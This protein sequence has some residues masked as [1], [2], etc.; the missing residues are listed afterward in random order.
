MQ[1]IVKHLVFIN[2]DVP[3]LG[4]LSP[5]LDRRG[6]PIE[7]VLAALERQTHRRFIKTHLALDGLPYFPQVKYIVVARDAR[8][9]FMSL[10]NHYSN[11]TAEQYANLNETPGQVGPPLPHAPDDLHEFWQE[12]MTRG[13]FPW[14]SEGYPFWGN[15]H[16]TQTW[17]AFRHLENL[18]FVHFADL[19]R[20]LR[21][22]I[23]RIAAFLDVSVS[24][25]ALDRIVQGVSLEEMRNEAQRTDAGLVK[26]FKGGA[27]TFFFKGVNGRWKEVLS[28]REL[29][30]YERKAG[31][32]LTPVAREWLERG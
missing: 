20:D 4:D 1:G 23:R 24:D 3:P 18:L 5:W 30:L 11:Y 15:L 7:E 12:W 21:G 16:H 28:G 17:W 9:V 19:S 10:W 22:E 29:E 13:W 27:E 32:L 31:D 14:E 6:T 8:D 25:G 2:Q 26:S